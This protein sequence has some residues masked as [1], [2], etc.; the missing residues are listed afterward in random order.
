MDLQYTDQNKNKKVFDQLDILKRREEED[1]AQLLATRYDLQYIDLTGITIDTN[2][3]RIIPEDRARKA[4]IACFNITNKKIL[5]AIKSPS[6]DETKNELLDLEKRGYSYVLYV[7]STQSLERAWS[8]Y[9][10]I[11]FATESQRGS[12]QVSNTEIENFINEVH[13]TEDA[14]KI[15]S[16]VLSKDKAFRIS[17]IVEITVAAAIATKASDIHIEPEQDDTRIRFR[18]DGVLREI[19]MIDTETYRLLLSRIKLLSGLKLNIKDNAQDGRFSIMIGETE[20]EIRS[21]VLPGNHGESVVMRLLDP[22]SLS[23]PIENLGMTKEIE[24]IVLKEVDKPDGMILNTGPT[25]SGKTTALYAFLNRKRGPGIKI[26]TIEDPIEY[27]LSGVVQTQ[28][29][30]AKGYEFATGLRSSLRQD[31]DVIMV[32]EIRDIETAETAIHAALT[33]HIVFSTLHTNNAAGAFARLIDLGLNPK[34]LTSAVTLVVAQRLVRKI[35][36]NCKKEIEHDP[37]TLDLLKKIYETI[38]GEKPSF[39]EKFYG[40]SGCEKCNFTGYKGRIGVFEALPVTKQLQE[41][42]ENNPSEREIIRTAFQN[43]FKNMTQDGILKIVNG[44]TT[45]EEVKRVVNLDLE[46]IIDGQKKEEE[47]NYLDQNL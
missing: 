23:V 17:R 32:G 31:P 43:G 38:P 14:K 2:A 18:L 7:C 10:D 40:P 15:I 46:E 37:Q 33:G 3:L 24:N 20:I 13:T 22:N 47:V 4:N 26:I 28:V 12:L 25:G 9:A 35:C 45:F 36:L 44:I 41:T 21:S 42:I 5:V 19:A 1:L 11:S 6:K 29:D 39:P 16:D 8:R 27:K 34:I 30:R